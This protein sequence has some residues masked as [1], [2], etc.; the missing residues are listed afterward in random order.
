MFVLRVNFKGHSVVTNLHG[1]NAT[2]RLISP[3]MHV[4][5]DYGNDKLYGAAVMETILK[6]QNDPPKILS[7][8]DDA[9]QDL[10]PKSEGPQGARP[11]RAATTPNPVPTGGRSPRFKDQVQSVLD[12]G[13]HEN[14]PA[15]YGT[16]TMEPIMVQAVPVRNGR[17]PIGRHSDDT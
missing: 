7:F 10:Q 15:A 6:L 1:C 8:T 2:H 11:V 13:H 12:C 9:V 5:I 16:S 14:A 17:D 4:R 3:N